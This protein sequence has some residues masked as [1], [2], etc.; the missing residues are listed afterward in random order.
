MKS[1]FEVQRLK[2][3]WVHES[4]LQNEKEVHS[5]LLKQP[6]ICLPFPGDRIGKI[7][8]VYLAWDSFLFQASTLHTLHKLTVGNL[9][10]IKFCLHFSCLPIPEQDTHHSKKLSPNF[11]FKFIYNQFITTWL[12]GGF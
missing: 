7:L 2:L 10:L 8:V 11:Y 12:C 9:K 4:I 6:L 5:G 3:K 1:K